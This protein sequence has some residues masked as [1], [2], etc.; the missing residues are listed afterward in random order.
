M[1]ILHYCYNFNDLFFVLHYKWYFIDLLFVFCFCQNIFLQFWIEKEACFLL[2]WYP[3]SLRQHLPSLLRFGK[4]QPCS[5][6]LSMTNE[7]VHS[8]QKEH[9]WDLL[10]IL[11]PSIFSRSFIFGKIY[12]LTQKSFPEPCSSKF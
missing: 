10:K 11:A 8:V 5:F 2:R 1:L 6:P 12:F 3:I 9:F 7:H 4:S